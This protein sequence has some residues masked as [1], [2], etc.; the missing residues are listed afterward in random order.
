MIEYTTENIAKWTK[1]GMRKSFGVIMK[2]LAKEHDD[3]IV[4]V[5]DVASSANLVEFANDFPMQFYNIGI[6]EQNML[7]IAAGLAKEG[8]NV[9]VVSFAPF[10]SMRTFETVR[11]LIGYMHLNVKVVALASGLSLGTQGSTHFCMEDIA[12]MRTI[13][14]LKLLSPADCT[15]EAKCLEYLSKYN[16]PAYLRLTGIDGSP[17]VYKEDFLFEIGKNELVREGEDIAI[18]STG[19]IVSECIRVARALKKDDLSCSV[20]DIHSIKP[21]DI[22]LIEKVSEKYRLIV[23]VEEHNVVGGLG[24]TMAEVLAKIQNHP[25]LMSLGIEDKFPHAGTYS[26]LL[27]QCGL[28]AQQMKERIVEKYRTIKNI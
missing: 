15:E 4:L 11:T 1:L 14:G 19:S 20:I 8:Y 13:P 6:A 10:V 23:T 17:S 26:Y 9:F 12:L 25:P 5:A 18:F 16:G 21:I 3:L 7:A 2:E 22:S 28:T 27:Q 24:S